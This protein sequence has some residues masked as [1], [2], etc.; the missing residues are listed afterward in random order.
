MSP[1]R[2]VVDWWKQ[3]VSCRSECAAM[4]I[5]VCDAA[6]RLLAAADEASAGIGFI[7]DEPSSFEAVYLAASARSAVRARASRLL[8][9]V[10][11]TLCSL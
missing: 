11:E 10:R 6:M 5:P 9:N 1:P 7:S 2:Q 4:P 3:L 8:P